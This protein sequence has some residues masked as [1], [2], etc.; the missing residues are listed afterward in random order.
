M[1][2]AYHIKLSGKELDLLLS[3]LKASSID[4][5]V[6]EILT[7]YILSEMKEQERQKKEHDK[8]FKT[9]VLPEELENWHRTKEVTVNALAKQTSELQK[10]LFDNLV[11]EI[12]VEYFQFTESGKIYE[13]FYIVYMMGIES[14]LA[15]VNNI[16]QSKDSYFTYDGVYDVVR[17][18]PEP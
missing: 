15:Q 13:L 7:N 8:N 18:V 3:S 11:R 6:V 4:K 16:I 9:F 2:M 17:N 1:D 10:K 12:I 14:G 5:G